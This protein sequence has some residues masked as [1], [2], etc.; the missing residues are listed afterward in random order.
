MCG[1]GELLLA[2]FYGSLTIDGPLIE[3]QTRL[4][5]VGTV[6]TTAIPFAIYTAAL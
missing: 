6:L 1:I 5:P 3:H 2:V 4:G